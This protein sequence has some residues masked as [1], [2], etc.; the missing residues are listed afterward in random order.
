MADEKASA[1]SRQEK[2][3][4]GW[5][6]YRSSVIRAPMGGVRP[7]RFNRAEWLEHEHADP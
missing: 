3:S 7:V 2:R 6:R 1:L 5:R 4:P